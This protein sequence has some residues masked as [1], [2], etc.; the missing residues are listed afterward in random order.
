M[1]KKQSESDK[2]LEMF[3]NDFIET[4]K[5]NGASPEELSYQGSELIKK[6]MKRFYE[7]ALQGEMDEHLGYAKGKPRAVEHGNLR[8]GK[9]SKKVI[10]ENGSLEIDT[11]RDRHGEFEPQIIAKHQ[12]RLPGFNQKVLYL[13][14]QGTSQ[15]D[16]QEQLEEIYQVE[17][18]QELISSVTDAVLTD[19]KEWRSRPL[20]KVYPIVYLDA[21]VTKVHG[22]GGVSNRAVYVALGV[23]LE[24]QKDV[25]G[26]W[27]GENEGSKFWLRVLTEMK[28]RGLE[29]ILIACVD[30]L[31]GFSDAIANVYPMTQVQ[32]CIVHAVRNS[33]KF[34]GWK[35]RKQVAADLKLIYQSPTLEAA[36]LQL[37][38]FRNKWDSKHPIIGEQWT[39]DWE[40]LSVLFAYPADIRRAI[41]TTN[42]IESL[43]HSL[44]KVLKNKK[45][46]PSEDALMKVLY[47]SIERASKKWTM[48]IQNWGPALARFA[49]EFGDRVPNL[50]NINL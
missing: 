26:L 47:L 22:E 14:G 33:L 5:A 43:N 44:R 35:E 11:P 31:S 41:Y 21:L 29:D 7:S 23:D 2:A 10:T 9:S 20:D 30:G 19:V 27:L 8:N 49:M 28:N 38:T 6:L 45:A 40:Q 16:I 17:V 4:Q 50:R 13:Y 48:P 24:G 1:K 39:R 36:E 18:S 12:R 37:E 46:F 3:F 42:A 32:R 15:R 25:L 34:V